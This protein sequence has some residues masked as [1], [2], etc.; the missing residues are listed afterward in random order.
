[1]QS[2][3]WQTTFSVAR[4]PEMFC[5]SSPPQVIGFPVIYIL[6]EELSNQGGSKSSFLWHYTRPRNPAG[7]I[8]YGTG[9]KLVPCAW[10]E[11]DPQNLM[12]FPTNP[13][14]SW[15][16]CSLINENVSKMFPL[17]KKLPHLCG[18]HCIMGHR[19][20]LIAQSYVTR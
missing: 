5:S 1:M 14:W 6:F 4:F 9:E 18:L 13:L 2:S 19:L 20:V 7:Q 15:K 3:S 12:L 16:L 8:N 17:V 11:P 10:Q